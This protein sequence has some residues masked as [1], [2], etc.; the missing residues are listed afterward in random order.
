[1]TFSYIFHLNG[2]IIQ[3][4]FRQTEALLRHW[5]EITQKETFK[6]LIDS[7]WFR[8]DLILDSL[9]KL[10]CPQSNVFCLCRIQSASTLTHERMPNFTDVSSSHM[11]ELHKFRHPRTCQTSL[12]QWPSFQ[13][14]VGTWGVLRLLQGRWGNT[15]HFNHRDGWSNGISWFQRGNIHRLW[16]LRPRRDCKRKTF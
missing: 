4:C 5:I 8:L 6:Q 11:Q 7:A 16:Q 3:F 12:T 15:G 9:W 13:K 2:I 10:C 14:I 1:M